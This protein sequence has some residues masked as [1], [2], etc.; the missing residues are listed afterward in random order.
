VFRGTG[1]RFWKMLCW[2]G[3][4]R[5]ESTGQKFFSAPDVAGKPQ[6]RGKCRGNAADKGF[7]WKRKKLKAALEERS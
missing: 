1:D 3:H 7:L 2:I 5:K 4:Q 6:M